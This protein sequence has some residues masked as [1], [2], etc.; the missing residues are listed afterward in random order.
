MDFKSHAPLEA[1]EIH[2]SVMSDAIKEEDAEERGKEF[3]EVFRK[4]LI[5]FMCSDKG[6]KKLLKEAKVKEAL[7]IALP[8]ALAAMGL[9][10]LFIPAVAVIV[11]GLLML[12]LNVGLDS[13][14]EVHAKG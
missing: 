12:L 3:W 11:T 6:I 5:E 7:L 13:V 4:K 2:F 10:A 1:M 14:C 9:T 8:A